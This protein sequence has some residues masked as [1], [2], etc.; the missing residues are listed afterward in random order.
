VSSILP[1]PALELPTGDGALSP[2]AD[3]SVRVLL[4]EDDA[5][6]RFL[7]HQLVA[8]AQY[9]VVAVEDGAA[10][11]AALAEGDFSIVLTDWDMPRM[12]GLALC[13]HI[14]ATSRD[15]YVYVV[16]LTAKGSQHLVAGLEAG[17]DDYVTKPVSKAELRARLNTG[18]RIVQLERSLRAATQ[19]AERLSVTD[20]LTGAFNRR[21]LVEQ[22]GQEIVRATRYH[23]SLSVMLC[24]IDHFKLVNDAHGHQA[25]DDV[26]RGFVR[27]LLSRLRSV[28]WMAR[29]GGEEF[30]VV[31]PETT[32]E[33]ATI[34]AEIL[35][36]AVAQAAHPTA[37]GPVAVTASFGV[38]TFRADPRA[39]DPA[40][41]LERLVAA[42]DGALY[43][44]KSR[45]R[46]RVMTAVAPLVP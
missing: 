7:T 43:D 36:Q 33:G 27:T 3:A 30:L 38:A 45:G 15:G 39:S 2:P 29:Y 23:R 35:R 20:A 44:A 24:D 17:A 21:Y 18:R 22:L 25:G 14:R 11:V 8:Q 28:D 19:R 6:T 37:K 26:L 42:A 4:A 12:D 31:L 16:L 10:A 40:A 9:D 32:L 41:S 46:N 34:I 5:T 13:R 1:P